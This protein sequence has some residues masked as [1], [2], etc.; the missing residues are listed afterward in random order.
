MI[1]NRLHRIVEMNPGCIPDSQ[2]GFVAGKSTLDAIS[3]SRML[4]SHAIETDTPLFKCYID[5]TKA[6]D[7]VNKETVWEILRRLGTPPKLVNL[8]ASL[9]NGAMATVKTDGCEQ[10][11]QFFLSYV[12]A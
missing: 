8:I 5:L 6:Y 4:A 3:V 12:L 1:L 10:G 11:A 9:H 2:C 7:R